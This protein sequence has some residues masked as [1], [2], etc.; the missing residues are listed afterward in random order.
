MKIS[1]FIGPILIGFGIFLIMIG[2][3]QDMIISLMSG[4]L[5]IIAT[6]YLIGQ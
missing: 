2:A 6:L 1:Y 5:A 4:I 3:T